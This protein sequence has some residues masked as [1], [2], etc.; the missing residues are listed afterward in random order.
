MFIKCEL[1]DND[2][3]PIGGVCHSIAVIVPGL[4]IFYRLI[5]F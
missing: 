4:L 3:S 1:I 5:F 2:F